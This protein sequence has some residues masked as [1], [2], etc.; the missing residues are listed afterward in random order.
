MSNTSLKAY[1]IRCTSTGLFKPRMVCQD[2]YLEGGFWGSLEAARAHLST[3]PNGGWEV[4]EYA[5]CEVP[6]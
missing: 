4:V 5:L 3:E 1:K 2:S 6:T